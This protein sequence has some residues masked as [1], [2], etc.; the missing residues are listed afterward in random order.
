M[1]P[2]KKH[3]RRLPKVDFRKFNCLVAG[4]DEV[5]RGCLAGPVVAAS[6]VLGPDFKLRGL[7]DSKLLTPEERVKF[8]EKIKER[9]ISWAVEF[10]SVEEIEKL[11]ILWASMEAMK[12]AIGKLHIKPELVLVD[13]KTKIPELEIPQQTLI[14]GD[15]RCL[16]IS[17]ASVLAKVA[18]D[19]FMVKLHE[20]FPKYGF[21]DHKGYG[22]PTHRA[23]IAAHGITVWH[24]K[25]F[26]GVAEFTGE[27]FEIDEFENDEFEI[28]P[29]S[30]SRDLAVSGDGKSPYSIN[31]TEGESRGAEGAAV[32]LAAKV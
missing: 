24:R 32:A 19:E 10:V 25:T 2:P 7:T 15:L 26:S 9:A 14:K 11:N 16:S 17:A 20:E 29:E 8:A 12:R 28:E 18:R 1:A 27:D 13:G 4:A 6:V 5:G 3:I 31:S 22:T 21:A 30:E 23:A